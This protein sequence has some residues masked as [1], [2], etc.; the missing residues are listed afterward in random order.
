MF[1]VSLK[2]PVTENDVSFSDISDIDAVLLLVEVE[3]KIVWCMIVGKDFYYR[4]VFE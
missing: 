1:S 2:K 3:K 4:E